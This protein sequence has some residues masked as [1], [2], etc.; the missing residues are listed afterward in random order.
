MS[1]MMRG[2]ANFPQAIVCSER[3]VR[4]LFVE[5]ERLCCFLS[6]SRTHARYK[7]NQTNNPL[8]HICIRSEARAS[9]DHA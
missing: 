1:G 9:L 8:P 5:A 3:F 7:P 4:S 6:R 2:G